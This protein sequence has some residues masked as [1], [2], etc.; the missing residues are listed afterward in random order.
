MNILIASIHHESNTFNPNFTTI[1]DF[2][3]LTGEEILA[4]SSNYRGT[5]L[6]G[7][8]EIFKDHEVE[9]IP[10]VFVQPYFE[11]GKVDFKTYNRFKERLIED[12]RENK[13]NIDGICLALHGS[14]TVEK[15]GDAEG[16]LLSGIREIMGSEVMI[17]S[18]LDMH[19]MVTEKMLDNGDAFVSYRT[20]PHVDKVNTGRRTAKLLYKALKEDYNLTTEGVSLPIL[21]SGEKSESSLYPMTEL[22]EQLKNSDKKKGILAT[23][24]CLGFPWADLSFNQASALVVSAEKNSELAE[25]ESQRLADLFWSYRN[26]FQFN[27][28]AYS[29]AEAIKIG[30]ENKDK[31]V[32][33]TDSGDNP[34]AGGSENITYPLEKIIELKAKNTLFAVIADKKA[35]K[36]CSKLGEGSEVELKLGQKDIYLDSPPTDLSGRITKIDSYNGTK[37]V[38]L[39]YKENDL[40]ITDRQV[41]MTD[42][43]FLE[44][45]G[46]ELGK[47]QLIILKSGYLAPDFRPYA[48]R[49]ILGLAPGYTNQV[50][51]ELPYKNIERPI[52]PLDRNFAR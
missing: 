13:D 51:K 47:Y 44:S 3:Y 17:V 11:G 7:I 21:L 35:I 48:K 16:D 41:V 19:A 25:K 15:I 42:P 46:L 43:K 33:I 29:M 50:F 36:K 18:A 14:M 39:N 37:A 49:T 52:F 9:M 2:K 22:I 32:I 8:V 30:L 40:V 38:V 27:T 1:D 10:S 12:V 23:S 5:S 34:G 45:L 24:Y 31:P 26:E 4:E 28:E 6:E 20:A